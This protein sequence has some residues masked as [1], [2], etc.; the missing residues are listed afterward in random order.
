[1]TDQRDA[2]QLQTISPDHQ[3]RSSNVCSV[4]EGNITEQFSHIHTSA[5]MVNAIADPERF[6]Q[7]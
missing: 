5:D 6:A 1:M 7:P 4:Q 2:E 3:S